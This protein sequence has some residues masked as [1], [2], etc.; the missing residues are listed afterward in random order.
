MKAVM[1]DAAG[2]LLE[3]TEPVPEVRFLEQ[4]GALLPLLLLFGE[5]AAL[6]V[7]DACIWNQQ[8]CN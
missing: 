5:A 4:A 1:V 6:A 7:D 3:P 8:A 2:T